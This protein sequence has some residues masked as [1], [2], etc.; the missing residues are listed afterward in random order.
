MIIPHAV[1][2]AWLSPEHVFKHFIESF[3]GRPGF[4]DE[5]RFWL[6]FFLFLCPP[7]KIHSSPFIS[8]AGACDV[9][10]SDVVKYRGVCLFICHALTP[11]FPGEPSR[12][13]KSGGGKDLYT[14]F[15]RDHT[16]HTSLCLHLV[17]FTIFLCP[18][19]PNHHI[20]VHRFGNINKTSVIERKKKIKAV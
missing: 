5:L 9:C 7:I 12:G 18:H 8:Y 19:S 10:H 3:H 11:S 14:L 15:V 2:S 4:Q 1:S 17:S 20:H 16:H 13:L 6:F